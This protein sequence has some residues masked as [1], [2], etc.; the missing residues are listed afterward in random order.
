[1]KSKVVLLFIAI[2]S[3]F[4]FTACSNGHSIKNELNYA[5]NS[6]PLTADPTLT[7]DVNTSVFNAFYC[8]TLY[9]Y[10]SDKKLVPGLAESYEVSEDGLTYTFHL[11]KDLKWSDGRQ[12]TANDFVYGFKRLADPNVGSNS[13]YFITDCCKLKNIFD[14]QDGEKTLSELGVSAPDNNTFI[15][16]LE[17]PC[18]YFLDLITLKN[19]APCNEDF[20]HSTGNNFGSS[21][22]NILSSGPYIID[23][24][25]PLATQIHFKKNPYYYDVDSIKIEG[26]NVQIIADGQQALMCYEAGLVDIVSVS[27]ELLELAESDPEL[28]IFT[29]A[30]LMYLDVNQVSSGPE[31]QNINI[32]KALT[33]SIDRQDLTKNLLK[34]GN[35]P[36]TRI[37]PKGFYAET[38]GTDFAE[39]SDRYT[40]AAGYDK[41]E[42]FKYWKQGLSELGISEIS[43]EFVYSSDSVAI[44]EAIASQME[45]TLPGLTVKLKG[46]PF[47]ERI[48]LENQGK[49]DLLFTGWSA[50]YSDPTS[51]LALFLSTGEAVSYSNPEY[52]SL[53][54]LSCNGEYINKPDERNKI[55]HSLEDMIMEDAGTIPIFTSGNTYLIKSYVS[56][57][58]TPPTGTGIIVTDLFKKVE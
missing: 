19:F 45:K 30:Q 54:S 47:K 41:D 36:I 31:L 29:S 46:V 50:D 6:S 23:R 39:N 3:V 15:V 28:H 33:K 20:F 25:E 55:L 32:R 49:Y 17:E 11:R 27:G 34:S 56:G 8:A 2:L 42:A 9:D 52:D 37:I 58:Q 38:D 40:E 1:M 35:E 5:L 7:Y 57:L 48:T 14:I 44:A 51:F 12:L 22:S 16:E 24:Y 4:L 21:E 10:N 13:I 26:I 18:S 43:L 53:Y